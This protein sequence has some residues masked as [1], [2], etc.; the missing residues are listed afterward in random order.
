MRDVVSLLIHLVR[1]VFQLAR[2]RGLRS[3]LAE[4]VLLKHQLVILNRSRRRAPNLRMLDRFLAGVCS[5]F[6]QPSRLV[7]SAIILKPSTLL[8]FHQLLVRCK[9]RLLFTPKQ[10]AKPGPKGPSAELICAVVEM[11]LRT[12]SDRRIIG[13]CGVDLSRSGAPRRLP[14]NF[15]LRF[16]RP[17]KFVSN[18]SS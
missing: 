7:R 4:S 10:R 12:D 17:P 6:I 15:E 1:T 2:H 9:Y 13:C 18:G 3:V 11:K 16:S 5:L 14:E 8:R